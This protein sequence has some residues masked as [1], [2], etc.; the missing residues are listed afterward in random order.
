MVTFK[1]IRL[2]FRRFNGCFNFSE[3]SGEND[4][5]R[6]STEVHTSVVTQPAYFIYAEKIKLWR[7]VV[8]TRTDSAGMSRPI[9]YNNTVFQ[10]LK[11]CPGY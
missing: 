11:I 6:I 7:D 3:C 9:L 8:T 10:I 2:M 5:I 4:V 1:N